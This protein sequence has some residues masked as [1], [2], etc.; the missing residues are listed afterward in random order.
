MMSS[1]RSKVSGAGCKRDITT[2]LSIIRANWPN[3]LMMLNVVELSKPVE[4]SSMKSAVVGPTII[5]PE[6]TEQS[7]SRPT[8]LPQ[9]HVL[10]E[11]IH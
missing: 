4:I 11:Y 3:V 10:A 9:S 7:G 8:W 6:I 2:V 1:N 5:S